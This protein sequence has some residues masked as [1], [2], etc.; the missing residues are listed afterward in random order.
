MFK[1]INKVNLVFV[2]LLFSSLLVSCASTP[3]EIYPDVELIQ[4]TSP[5]PQV[6]TREYRPVCGF[7][8]DGDLKTFSNSCTAC[9]S[10]KVTSYCEGD[11]N[12]LKRLS[13]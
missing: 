12:A 5:K 9:S 3:K 2:T 10:P 4:C 13:K 8:N 7:E 6:C 11:C 1:F